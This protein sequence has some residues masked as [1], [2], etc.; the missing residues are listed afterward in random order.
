[1]LAATIA[2]ALIFFMVQRSGALALGTACWDERLSRAGR[3]SSCVASQPFLIF[4][5]GKA[6]HR[7]NLEGKHR[8]RLLAGVG[9]SVLF[10]F[11]YRD[12]DVYWADK[13]TGVIYKASVR[14]AQ[15]QKLH[16]SDKH[17]SG[18]AVDWIWNSVY[19]TSREKGKIKRMDLNGKNERTL[20][21]HLNQPSSIAVDPTNRFLFWLSGG[22][23]PS[24]QRSDLTG[25]EKTTL[26]KMSEQLNSLT[27][28]R[29]DKRLFWV[30]FGLQ[31]ESAIASCDYNGNALHIK[32]QPLWS[33]VLGISV[34]LENLYYTDAG[35]RIIKQMNKYT[36]GKALDVNTKQMTR[37]PIQIKVV[38]PLNQ[39]L[40]DSLSSFPGCDKQTGNCMNVCSNMAEQGV[41]HCTE[42][43]ALSK[44]GTHCEDVNECA[45]WNHGCSLGCENIPGS[46]FCT[47]PKGYALLPDR[48]TC[49]EILPCEGNM[50]NCGHGC[51]TTDEGNVCVCPEGSIL[52]EDGQA[53][54][55][56][57]STDMGGCSQL[58]TPVTP[59]E[60]QCGCLPGYRLHQDGKRCIATGPPPYLLVANFVDVLRIN[61]DGTGDQTLVEEPRGT[62][63]AL[64]YDPVQENVYFS[65]INRKT[66]ERVDL[67]GG[68]RGIVISEDLNSPEGLAID[69]VHRRMYWTDESRSTVDCSSL[70]GLSRETIV[71]KGLEKPRG[72][73]VHPLEKKLFWTD[74]GAQPVVESASLEGKERTI[75]ASTNLVSPSGLAIDFTEDRLFWCD[76]HRGLV[77]TA[78]LDGSDRRVLLENQVGRPFDLAVF[79]DRLW[80]SDREHRQLT[81]VHKRTGKKLQSI[82]GNM[83]QPAA[84]VVVHPLAKPGADVCLHLNGGCAQVC[85][86]K[87]GLA[88]CSCL[89]RYILSADRRSCSS[90]D[91]SNE[92]AESGES[93]PTDVTSLKRS[94]PTF[95]TDKMVSDQNEC[96]SLRCDVNAQCLLRARSPACLCLEGFTGDGQVCEEPEA[97]STLLTT[98][99]PADVTTLHHISDSVESCPPSHE[100]YCLYQGVCF[101]F[102]ELKSY[103]CNCPLGYMGERC[104]FSDLEWWE[105]QQAE[106]E[107]RRN[108]VIA[109]SMVLLISLL[110]IAACVTYCYGTRKFFRKQPS[111]DNV[112]ET[113]VTDESTSE[114]TPVPRVRPSSPCY[115]VVMQF[116][117][118]M[119]SGAEGRVVPAMGCPRRAICP[120][121]SS[122]TGDNHVSEETETLSKHNR[123]Y[124]C[125]MVSAVAMEITQ[126]TSPSPASSY[127][128]SSLKPQTTAPV[129]KTTSLESPAS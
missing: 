40:A 63:V 1:M 80:I 112:S 69:W 96:D 106:E 28:D 21:R 129:S 8:R 16:S 52:Q 60:W 15:K 36:G 6:V 111:V 41:C 122:D 30:Q 105:L 12:E 99:S 74:I 45:H 119:E 115:S 14:G 72:I 104:Q 128:C 83:V 56:C 125:S 58:C 88:H 94:E 25:L 3:N 29:Q 116:Y 46:Y 127:T 19:W 85:E 27:I 26:I 35:S 31:G 124:E 62:I 20:L 22:M 101:Y 13:H 48:K 95:F 73:I 91:A 100:S 117:L 118:L 76:Q 75:I 92:T 114:T 57:S 70:V 32:D 38:H 5:H 34:F 90:A 9:R 81:S 109:A 103:A 64:D 113:S 79:E 10:D 42:G 18:L 53:C 102:P 84:I 67:N 108:V 43:F 51:L 17:I 24:I 89:S 7:M 39:P 66:I 110:S 47:C 55:G 120:S 86:S 107:K 50:T 54:T 121:C 4:G 78:A 77:E 65:S 98:R 71:S 68:S 87:L 37:P 126:P 93:D 59:S 97:A 61:P 23:T 123:G 44:Q 49:G 33:R 11:H 2:A 82:H